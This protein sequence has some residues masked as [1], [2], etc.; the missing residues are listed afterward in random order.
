MAVQLSSSTL[1]LMLIWV[2]HLTVCQMVVGEVTEPAKTCLHYFLMQ[3][4]MPINVVLSLVPKVQ[5]MKL[6][7][8]P[9]DCA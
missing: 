9:M 1:V 3:M 8:L 4:A 5:W 2:L 7:C 6:V